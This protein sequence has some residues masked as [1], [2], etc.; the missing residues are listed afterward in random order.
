[1]TP[2]HLHIHPALAAAK[3]K[4][5]IYCEKPLTHNIA[6]GRLL[7]SSVAQN[8]IIFQT[9][10]Q[11]RCEFG[12]RFRTAVELIQAGRI[13]QLKTIRV[14]VGASP[15]ACNLPGQPKPENVD[16]DLW[17][18]PA[19]IRE[20]HEDLCPKGVHNHFPAFRKYEEYAGGLLAD[21]G[22]HHFDIAQWAM[23]MDASGPIRIEPP[24][25]GD[26]GLKFTYASGVE[27]LHGGPSG[28]T[29][30]G[31]EGVIYVDRNKLESNKT[32]IL[33]PLMK[34]TGSAPS[35]ND[36]FR[37]WIESIKARKTPIC[38]VETGHRSATVCHLANIGYKLRRKL[39]WDPVAE[40][41]K[42]DDAANALT[43]RK[44]R[45]GWEYA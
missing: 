19:P 32:E 20:Y 8:N 13:G 30:E 31:S 26:T 7:V 44:P 18:G 40:I 35:P 37:D 4:L 5:D 21:M 1:M 34:E 42:N 23:G 16:W 22:A 25:S 43:I 3:K 10:S 28:C 17:L 38:S 39:E 29:F 2:D 36:H 11:Q 9:G 15:V 14:G 41:F 45:A 6:E 24:A 12:G 33:V 27:M